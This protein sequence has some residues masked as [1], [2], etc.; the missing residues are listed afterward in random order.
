[1]KNEV[2]ET[3]KD[4]NSPKTF[5]N[6]TYSSQLLLIRFVLFRFVKRNNNHIFHPKHGDNATKTQ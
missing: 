3:N 2:A 4:S 6:A 5:W 1:M